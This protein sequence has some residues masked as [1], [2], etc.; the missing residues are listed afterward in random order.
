MLLPA[1]SSPSGVLATPPVC[2]TSLMLQIPLLHAERN[3]AS[4]LHLAALGASWRRH[5]AHPILVGD[6]CQM[7]NGTGGKWGALK[8][9]RSSRALFFLLWSVFLLRGFKKERIWQ[10]DDLL[11]RSVDS[12]QAKGGQK[13]RERDRDREK[14]SDEEVNGPTAKLKLLMVPQDLQTVWSND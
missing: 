1:I 5:I 9:A 3:S 12:S 10:V 2:T 7:G 6:S 11:K 4:C 13:E 8:G 14:V